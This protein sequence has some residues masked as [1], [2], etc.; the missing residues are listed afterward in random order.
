MPSPERINAITEILTEARAWIPENATDLDHFLM[1]L[2]YLFEALASSIAGVAERLASEFPVDPA[3]PE[4][5]QEIAATI[6]GMG[7]FAGEAHGIHRVV[8]AREMEHI[9]NSRPN[10]ATVP[11]REAVWSVG[12][13]AVEF[14]GDPAASS[15]MAVSSVGKGSEEPVEQ[16]R[17]LDPNMPKLVTFGYGGGRGKEGGLDYAPY[18][19]ELAESSQRIIRE[20]VSAITSPLNVRLEPVELDLLL[21]LA[22]GQTADQF[23]R[24]R[25]LSDPEVQALSSQLRAKM[26]VPNLAAAVYKGLSQEYIGVRKAEEV[27]SK[28]VLTPDQSLHLY[29]GGIGIRAAQA[30]KLVGVKTPTVNSHRYAA[31]DSLGVKGLP[32]AITQAFRIGMYKPLRPQSDPSP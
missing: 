17:P 31:I 14:N 21:A 24:R 2:P 11:Y 22:V 32:V 18:S 26:G 15:H 10:A 4:H 25:R 23:K 3:V 7:E 13:I 16:A 8:Q 19:R 30:G 6:A 1:D 12:K 27:G 28:V 20:Q 29:L 5:L 9:E